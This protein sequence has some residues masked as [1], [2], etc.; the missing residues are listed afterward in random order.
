M[1]H[2]ALSMEEVLSNKK[3]VSLI[4]KRF[5]IEEK[6]IEDWLYESDMRVYDHI[7]IDVVIDSN[8]EVHHHYG[9]YVKEEADVY[10]LII[11]TSLEYNFDYERD[12]D[13]LTIPKS[14]LVERFKTDFS[15][16]FN[17]DNKEYFV[18]VDEI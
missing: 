2:R 12:K 11:P 13:L 7:D 18:C 14:K 6:D 3:L 1:E 17:I 10:K 4:S 8:F 5:K 9:F 15:D 16:I